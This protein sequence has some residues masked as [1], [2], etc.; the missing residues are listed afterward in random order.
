MHITNK[1]LSVYIFNG[2]TFT[3]IFMEHDLY[4]IMIF[5]ITEKS[6]IL[7]PTMYFGCC[8]KYNRVTGFMTGFVVQGH[9]IVQ[10]CSH[11]KTASCLNV[12]Q[13]SFNCAQL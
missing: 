1:Q 3:I 4:L 12:C 10:I 9:I 5:G 13:S 6:V 11:Y 7:T 8:Y 2:S